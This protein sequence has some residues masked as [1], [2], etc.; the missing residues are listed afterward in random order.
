MG[1]NLYVLRET[2]CGITA[3]LPRELEA[4]ISIMWKTLDEVLYWVNDIGMNL[5]E[6]SGEKFE[7]FRLR[8]RRREA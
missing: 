2:V 1:S 3:D 7:P 4:T 5:E 8:G 6:F